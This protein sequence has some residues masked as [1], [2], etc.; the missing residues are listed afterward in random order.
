MCTTQSFRP[1]FWI[2][3]G[4]YQPLQATALLLADLLKRPTSPE[5]QRSRVLVEGVFSLLGPD[6]RVVGKQEGIVP[7]GVGSGGRQAWTMLRRLREKAWEK[8]GLKS[9]MV[10][11]DAERAQR[12]AAS[13]DIKIDPQSHSNETQTVSRA[14]MSFATAI[15]HS[16]DD[17]IITSTPAMDAPTPGTIHPMFS[18]PHSTA[19]LA[20][21]PPPPLSATAT[22][23]SPLQRIPENAASNFSDFSGGQMEPFAMPSDSFTPASHSSGNIEI[24]P[25]DTYGPHPTGFGDQSGFPGLTGLTPEMEM[26]LDGIDWGEWD[27]LLRDCF[28][29]PGGEGLMY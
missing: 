1:F 2:Y 24:W 8:A 16:P 5:A 25:Q 18:S 6:G 13:E 17:R 12:M 11:T 28:N 15:S 22:I 19:L 20:I 27:S 7:Q 14:P 26:D 23:D 9:N 21:P 3:P 4:L 10:W 29:V